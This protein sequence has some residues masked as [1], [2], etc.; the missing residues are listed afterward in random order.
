MHGVRLFGLGKCVSGYRVFV[1]VSV[2]ACCAAL[3]LSAPAQSRPDVV[4]LIGGTLHEDVGAVAFLPDGEHFVSTGRPSKLWRISGNRFVLVRTL[5]PNR[6]SV[7]H[8]GLYWAVEEHISPSENYVVVRRTLDGALIRRIR[9]PYTNLDP[10]NRALRLAVSSDGQYVAATYLSRTYLWRC[11]DGTQVYALEQAGPHDAPYSAVSFS[12]DDQYLLVAGIGVRR[13]RLADGQE[14]IVSSVTYR[15]VTGV[16]ASHDNEYI[17]L[18]ANHSLNYGS[19]Q[20]ATVYVLRTRDGAQLFSQNTPIGVFS[21]PVF[22]PDG[23]LLVIPGWNG[24]LALGV[25]RG[26]WRFIIP[27]TSAHA[28][29]FVPNADRLVS[30]GYEITLWQVGRTNWT[31]LADYYRALFSASFSPDERLIATNSVWVL[32][33]SDGS[34]V[35]SLPQAGR[36]AFSPDGTYLAATSSSG[37][38]I[39]RTA[40]W[41]LERTLPGWLRVGFSPDGQAL[42]LETHDGT[43]FYRT[44]D[45]TAYFSLPSVNICFVGDGRQFVEHDN[46]ANVLRVRRTADGELVR[47]VRLPATWQRSV[48]LLQSSPNGQYVMFRNVLATR[49]VL[50]LLRLS[51]GATA[52]IQT[53]RESSPEATFTPDG[54]YI[55]SVDRSS[56]CFWRMSDLRLALEYTEEIVGR[57]NAIVFSPSGRLFA[58]AREDG[59]LILL[60]NPFYRA[61]PGDVNRDSCV[62]EVDLIAV[63]QAFGTAG[64]ALPEDTND[65]GRVDDRDLLAVLFA[66]GEGCS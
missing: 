19:G 30:Y 37:V 59:T 12:R 22:S 6:I 3:Q 34:E 42:A 39:W 9:M 5:H 56:L 20:S 2:V 4:W 1:A 53:G 46:A 54:R 10:Y 7:S 43:V 17:A 38:R 64:A 26:E 32:R 29:A 18:V 60:R 31:R 11:T 48:Q 63:L 16:V 33:T 66:F 55:V 36:P 61:L 47:T 40:D 8:N 41:Q 49:W 25:P 27:R 45:W 24:I 28:V 65:D 62:N 44:S 58:Y 52:F 14:Q 51:D 23:Q 50:Y 13:V 15:S 57:P 35:V 21:S